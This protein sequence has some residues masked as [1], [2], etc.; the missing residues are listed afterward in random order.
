[1]PLVSWIAPA[2]VGEGWLLRPSVPHCWR[3]WPWR[4]AGIVGDLG[5]IAAASKKHIRERWQVAVGTRLKANRLLVPPFA[6]PPTAACPQG[7]PLQWLGDTAGAGEHWF[8]VPA[9]AALCACCWQAGSGPREFADPPADHETRLGRLPMNTVGNPRLLQQ[10]RPWIEPAQ[11]DAKNPLGLSQVFLNSL[12]LT[13]PMSLLADAV[14]LLRANALRRHPQPSLP[15]DE[16][17]PW[18]LALALEP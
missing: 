18:Q 17:T 1:M 6:T 3:R 13:W 8:G 5:D 9:G 10:V 14:G 7:P 11:S 12:R 2:N 16:L 4:P 15:L